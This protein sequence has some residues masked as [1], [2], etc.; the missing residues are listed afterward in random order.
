MI[1]HPLQTTR[2]LRQPLLLLRRRRL[3]LPHHPL[4]LSLSGEW[5]MP[6]SPNERGG[7]ES[8]SL[9]P[10][11]ID[12]LLLFVVDGA[13]ECSLCTSTIS[14]H[15][16]RSLSVDICSDQYVGACFSKKGALTAQVFRN[17]PGQ[18]KFFNLRHCLTGHTG[19]L[20][21][22]LPQHR[23]PYIQR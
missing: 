6:Y 2:L 19:P 13:S 18:F 11:H 16:L 23:C 1:R 7:R 5:V 22:L 10:Y 15:T 3:N 8:C 20:H 14:A 21:G 4:L 9:G 17:Q 12:G